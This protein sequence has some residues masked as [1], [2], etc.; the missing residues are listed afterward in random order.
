MGRKF[1]EQEVCPQSQ[2]VSS[3]L[4]GGEGGRKCKHPKVERGGAG[5][6]SAHGLEDSAPSRCLRDSGLYLHLGLWSPQKCIR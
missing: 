3:T 1:P 5:P 6:G 4:P 2:G